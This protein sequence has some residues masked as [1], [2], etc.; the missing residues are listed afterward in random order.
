MVPMR[1]TLYASVD[2]LSEYSTT[3][4]VQRNF[5]SSTDGT[6]CDQAP[7]G[8][9][10]P[11]SPFWY[12]TDVLVME[13]FVPFVPSVPFFANRAGVAQLVFAMEAVPLVELAVAAVT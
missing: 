11:E 13:T 9:V 4:F 5:P 2:V 3:V 12:V 7:V 1:D 8:A 6:F 10:V